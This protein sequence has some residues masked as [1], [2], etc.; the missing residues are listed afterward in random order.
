MPDRMT[1]FY[2]LGRFFYRLNVQIEGLRAFAQSRSNAGLDGAA[3]AEKTH[4]PTRINPAKFI[5][6]PLGDFNQ[7]HEDEQP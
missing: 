4:S 1:D 6:I 7:N 3:I 5:L 2:E